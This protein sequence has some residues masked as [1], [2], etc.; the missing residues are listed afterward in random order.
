RMAALMKQR[1]IYVLTHDSIGLGEDGPT[2]QPVEHLPSLRMIPNMTLW[3]PC[4][5]AETAQ[6]WADAIERENGPTCLALTRQ[7]LPA[8]PR[9]AEQ[10]AAIRRGGYVLKDCEGTPQVILIASGS[11]V[12]LAVEAAQALQQNGRRARVVSM[13]C[14]S[15]FDAQDA[16]YREQVLPPSV[17]R[18]VAIE[19]AAPDTWWRYV[20]PRGAVVGMTTFG[21]SGIAKDLFKHFG[22]SVDNVVRTVERVLA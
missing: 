16:G 6:A 17:E 12:A 22:F 11:E 15:V 1:V 13:P 2:H 7:G 5:V 19:A 14:T 10:V 9:S 3:R 20:G 21:A 8:Q 4:D 18:R